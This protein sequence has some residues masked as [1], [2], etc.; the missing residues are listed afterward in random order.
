MTGTRSIRRRWWLLL[1]LALLGGAA[2]VWLRPGLRPVTAR[3]LSA[4]TDFIFSVG[5]RGYPMLQA[6]PTKPYTPASVWRRSIPSVPCRVH[7]LGDDGRPRDPQLDCDWHMESIPWNQQ[8]VS[9]LR[10]VVLW[11]KGGACTLDWRD[12]RRRVFPA[13]QVSHRFIRAMAPSADGAYLDYDGGRFFNAD[14][15]RVPLP[16]GYSTLLT[17]RSADPRYVVVTDRK[18]DI[19]IF[20]LQTRHLIATLKSYGTRGML[21]HHGARFLLVTTTGSALVLERG[22]TIYTRHGAPHNWRWGED[23]TA[24]QLDSRSIRVLQWKAG[25]CRFTKLPVALRADARVQP[26]GTGN[27]DGYP[28]MYFGR[29][30]TG[31]VS[32][33]STSTAVWGDGRYVATAETVRLRPAAAAR[34]LERLARLVRIRRAV[35]REARRLTLYRDGKPAGHYTVPID[36]I[37]LRPLPSPAALSSIIGIATH[38]TTLTLTTGTG[39][40]Y[41]YSRY[42]NCREHLA[43]TGDGK[44]LSWLVFTGK[45]V[46]HV[47]FKVR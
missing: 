9:P 1:T 22:K 5:G 6:V 36:P 31:S 7:W 20:D 41:T 37:A 28:W 8:Y 44:H 10:E 34:K 35:P 43:F 25:P 42:G 46:R 27:N 47:V 21:F 12:G 23:G 39:K 13:A 2:G 40:T 11:Q 38:G 33:A 14:R 26:W 45:E 19:G 3:A 4:Q 16:A 30:L 32:S 29:S 15:K 24:W 18:N 17:L